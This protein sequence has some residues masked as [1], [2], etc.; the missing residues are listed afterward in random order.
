MIGTSDS[1]TEAYSVWRGIVEIVK[2]QMQGAAS[3][4]RQA[5]GTDRLASS[6]KNRDCHMRVIIARIEDAGGFV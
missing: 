5:V 6:E 2:A 4:N 3:R 1:N